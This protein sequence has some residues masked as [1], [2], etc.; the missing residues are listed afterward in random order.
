MSGS[1]LGYAA[2]RPR[3]A[4]RCAVLCCV[5]LV[6]DVRVCGSG[7][8]YAAIPLWCGA[9]TCCGSVCDA[10]SRL[11]CCSV[12]DTGFCYSMC[13]TDTGDAIIRSQASLSWPSTAKSPTQVTSPR[14]CAR[15]QSPRTVEPHTVCPSNTLGAQ[16]PALSARG[17]GA[18]W[19]ADASWVGSYN[20]GEGDLQGLQVRLAVLSSA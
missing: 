9:T 7:R 5:E 16:C 17:V 4:L 8:S 11:C 18:D 1:D 6:G 13:D 2:E 3:A 10:D 19:P 15:N 14:L 12:C 20:L